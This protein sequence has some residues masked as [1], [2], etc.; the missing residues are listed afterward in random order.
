[1]NKEM[2]INREI[3]NNKILLGLNGID[4]SNQ[5]IKEYKVQ[6]KMIKEKFLTGKMM[7]D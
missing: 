6:L 7:I 2:H 1:M 4:L 3:S 5:N